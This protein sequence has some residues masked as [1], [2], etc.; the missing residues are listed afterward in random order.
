MSET[1][2]NKGQV[3]GEILG[4]EK[5]NEELRQGIINDRNDVVLVPKE[6]YETFDKLKASHE[7]L[8]EALGNMVKQFAKYTS[9]L[10]Q[11]KCWE[12]IQARQALKEAGEI[13]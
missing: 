3:A 4:H 11:D 2:Y 6:I 9:Q 8:V 5:K 7:K 10:N 1:N 12:I 13:E